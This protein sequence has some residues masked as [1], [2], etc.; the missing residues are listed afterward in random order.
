M[1]TRKTLGKVIIG[2][3]ITLAISFLPWIIAGDDP[4]TGS[5]YSRYNV[6]LEGNKLFIYLLFIGLSTVTIISLKNSKKIVKLFCYPPL[7]GII[8]GLLLGIMFPTNRPAGTVANYMEFNIVL[9]WVVFGI[10]VFISLISIG[11][12][13]LKR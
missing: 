9:F 5:S 2:V 7:M 6:Y 8:I 1:N 13:L 4:I 11:T 10:G 3:A 12:S